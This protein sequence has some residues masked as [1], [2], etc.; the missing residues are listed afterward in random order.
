MRGNLVLKCS[1]PMD[2]L[3]KE[4]IKD[5]IAY[6]F[7]SPSAKVMILNKP[8]TT[9]LKFLAVPRHN[10]DGSDTD[11]MDLLNDLTAHPAWANVELWSNPKFINLKA[12]MAGA[13]VVVS[14]IDDNQ[15]NVG[16]RLMGTMVDFSGCT[17]P[18]K[19]W[20]ELPAQPFCSQCQSWGHPGARCPANVLICARCGGTHDFRQHDRY[21]ETCKKGPGHSCAPFCRNCRG[22]HMST[23]HE[24]PFW[25]G[26]TS[27][28]RH[29]ELYA[30]IEAKFP[31][32]DSKN[33][34][35]AAASRKTL[36]RKKVGFSGP[37]A[38]GFVQVGV[39][40][41]VARIDTVP[42]SPSPAPPNSV[43][44]AS[45]SILGALAD[46]ALRPE[47]KGNEEARRLMQ[48][49]LLDEAAFAAAD[50][51]D[52]AGSGNEAQPTGSPPSQLEYV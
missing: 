31:R 39:T 20:V 6:F 44:P 1:K 40:P 43:K 50:A 46:E 51:T 13:T 19:R 11:E 45:G 33:D 38:D 9:T 17:R 15:G 37:D 2:D 23:S 36:G 47:L 49:T 4:G 14:V 22:R 42:D 5:A 27:K 34:R 21:C 25:I 30:E 41:G 48:E 32:K 3:I 29:A 10:L 52:N 16:R 12:G 35:N 8:P 7:P 26:R 24:C 28:E 18:C